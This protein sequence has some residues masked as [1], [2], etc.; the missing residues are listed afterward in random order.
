M[1]YLLSVEIKLT[2]DCSNALIF[3]SFSV[4]VLVK[5]A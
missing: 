5:E 3:R 1:K 2:A 4:P